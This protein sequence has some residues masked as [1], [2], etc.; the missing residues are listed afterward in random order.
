MFSTTALALA[1]V[2]ALVVTPSFVHA[3]IECDT[4]LG[5]FYPYCINIPDG[6]S[7]S[8]QNYPTIVFL[9][10]SGARGPPSKVRELVSASSCLSVN[11]ALSRH[12]RPWRALAN[13]HPTKA[14]TQHTINKSWITITADDTPN[15]DDNCI[16]LS[17]SLLLAVRL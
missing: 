10:G 16:L 3:K 7:S 1:A 17:H 5:T 15:T 12:P 9:S 4:S 6:A 8:G 13:S 14:A 2:A 11:P